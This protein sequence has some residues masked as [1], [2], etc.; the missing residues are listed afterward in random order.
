MIGVIVKTDK[1]ADELNLDWVPESMNSQSINEAFQS[2]LGYS[3]G[4]E[5]FTHNS[6]GALIHFTI[7]NMR[8]PRAITFSCTT[9]TRESN[10][11]STLAAK[12]QAKIY[13]SE[14]CDFVQL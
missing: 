1:S 14:A 6:D 12:L 10:I 13:D 2:L 8:L 9:G 7:D 4:S 5:E 11:I 3:P